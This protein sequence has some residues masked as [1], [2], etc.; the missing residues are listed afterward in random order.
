MKVK[1]RIPVEPNIVRGFNKKLDG[2]LVV[3]DHLGFQCILPLSC[4]AEGDQ[5]LRL[6]QGVGI[7]F[8]IAG[9]PGEVD[10]QPAH[11]L[12]GHGA[13]RYG[14]L[15]STTNLVQMFA[16]GVVKIRPIVRVGQEKIATISYRFS[17][18]DRLA[19]MPADLTTGLGKGYE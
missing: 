6:Q 14:F 10:Q 17:T 9:C 2:L 3:Q 13:G 7:P 4:L 11:N 18:L 8:K 19:D 1:N 5:A 12:A 16:S 15:V